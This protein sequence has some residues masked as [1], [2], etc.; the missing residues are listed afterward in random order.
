MSDKRARPDPGEE[1][2]PEPQIDESLSQAE[3]DTVVGAC[4][5]S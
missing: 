2:R 5:T 4:K 1:T 3:L